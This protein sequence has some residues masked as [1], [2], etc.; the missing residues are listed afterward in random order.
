MERDLLDE[1][2]TKGVHPVQMLSL[3]EAHDLPHLP[4]GPWDSPSAIRTRRERYALAI[5][6]GVILIAPMI[7]MVLVHTTPASLVTVAVCTM[8]FAVAASYFSP[9][10]LPLELLSVTAAYAAVLV[11]FVGGTAGSV[12]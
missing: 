5:L 9:T 3:E 4:G 6:G 10:K 11:V 12:P 1:L 7:L 2:K 8:I